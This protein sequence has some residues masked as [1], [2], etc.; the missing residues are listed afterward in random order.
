M[1]MSLLT[2]SLSPV[3]L[4]STVKLPFWKL[5]LLFALMEQNGESNIHK[6][7]YEGLTCPVCKCFVM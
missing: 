6:E 7:I 3:R 1:S 2:I 4:E 5:G